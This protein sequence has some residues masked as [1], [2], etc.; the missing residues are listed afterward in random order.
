MTI[1]KVSIRRNKNKPHSFI[2][3]TCTD[4]REIRWNVLEF[5]E[6]RMS[7]SFPEFCHKVFPSEFLNINWVLL[8]FTHSNKTH[9]NP[10][11]KTHLDPVY[12]LN[13]VWTFITSSATFSPWFTLVPYEFRDGTRFCLRDASLSSHFRNS[14]KEFPSSSSLLFNY[15]SSS[16]TS[17]A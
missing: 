11:S 6:G 15:Y 9:L 4:E 7:T 5:G 10:G 13:F 3:T 8:S 17:C 16:F 2:S 14:N 12:F 1:V